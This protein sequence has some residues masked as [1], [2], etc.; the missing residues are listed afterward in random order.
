MTYAHRRRVATRAE[1]VPESAVAS[2]STHVSPMQLS[3]SPG[4]RG[5]PAPSRP[6]SPRRSP[7]TPRAPGAPRGR[8]GSAASERSPTRRLP[9]GGLAPA[10]PCG[11]PPEVARGA[12]RPTKTTPRRRPPRTEG[13]WLGEVR[14]RRS[15]PEAG[16]SVRRHRPPRGLHFASQPSRRGPGPGPA[17]RW[18]TTR[19][20][21]CPHARP[22]CCR[23]PPW[24]RWP[25]RTPG[26]A[27]TP[28]RTR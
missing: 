22:C 9:V 27:R 20:P 28:H 4:R 21:G 5:S 23:E 24:G 17:Q 11:G 2:N 3:T 7:E 15:R 19:S 25:T 8:R 13:C 1:P 12:L 18:R 14:A 6:Q 10:A 16:R 26:A